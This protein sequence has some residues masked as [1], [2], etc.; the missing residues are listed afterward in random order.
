MRACSC[1]LVLGVVVASGC[2]GLKTA[3]VSGTVKLDGKP[4][5]NASVTFQP[6]GEGNLN[7]GP[8]S[9]GVTNDKGEYTL[10]VNPQTSGAVLGKHRVEITSRIDDGQDNNP[11]EDRR[12]KARDRV[13]A[14]YNI[15]STLTYEVKSGPNTADW[16]LKS[17]P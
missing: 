14:Q 5:P 9:Y 13:P 4:L 12:T 15:R 17:K 6:V 16:D 10:A 7:P 3:Q 8:G 2:G 11:N 1:L